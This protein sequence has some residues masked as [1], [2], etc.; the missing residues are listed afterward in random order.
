L[1]DWLGPVL[2]VKVLL[3]VLLGHAQH[4][5]WSPCKNVFVASEE[6]DKLTFLFGAKVGPDLDGLGRVLNIYLDDLGIL[7][8]LEGASHGRHGRA[9]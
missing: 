6:V 7:D 3:S 2:D 4:L 8:S 5:Y 9:G 1:F